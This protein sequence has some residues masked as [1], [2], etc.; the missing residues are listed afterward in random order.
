MCTP[1]V[2]NRLSIQQGSLYVDV[3]KKKKK[4]K[5]QNIVWSVLGTF[6]DTCQLCALSGAAWVISSTRECL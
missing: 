4:E 5:T 1:G 6:V 2:I 3:A